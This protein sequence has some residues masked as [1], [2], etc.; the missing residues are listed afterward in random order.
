MKKIDKVKKIIQ[1]LKKKI[2]K[3]IL[4]IV[5]LNFKLEKYTN[6]KIFIKIIDMMIYKICI[7]NNFFK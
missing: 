2:I 3:E 1:I 4:L 7:Q 6:F 5:F